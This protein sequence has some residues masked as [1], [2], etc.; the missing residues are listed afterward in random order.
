MTPVVTMVSAS[1]V[2]ILQQTLFEQLLGQKYN[3][4]PTGVSVYSAAKQTH[5]IGLKWLQPSEQF[6]HTAG[7]RLTGY[8]TEELEACHL[9]PSTLHLTAHVAAPSC[10]ITHLQ[11]FKLILKHSNVKQ[12]HSE[13]FGL[14]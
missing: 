9:S 7:C 14:H 12:Q 5:I 1:V 6:S 10:S 11:Y 3:G 8:L 4:R 2:L 13:M